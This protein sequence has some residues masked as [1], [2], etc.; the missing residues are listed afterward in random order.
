MHLT[1]QTDHF[2]GGPQK[3]QQSCPINCVDYCECE[4]KTR[5]GNVLDSHGTASYIITRLVTESTLCQSPII[6]ISVVWD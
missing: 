1:E 3:A 2:V 4:V 6:K 5:A